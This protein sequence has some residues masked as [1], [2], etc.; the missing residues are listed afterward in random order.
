MYA[1]RSYYVYKSIFVVLNSAY[2][3]ISKVVPEA[4]SG[5]GFSIDQDVLVFNPEIPTRNNFV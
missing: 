3:E 5:L 4:I 1:I 2:D